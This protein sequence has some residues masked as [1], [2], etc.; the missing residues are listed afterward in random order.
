LKAILLDDALD[1][2][3]TD[4]EAGL[5]ELLGDDVGRGVEIEEA[6]TDDLSF[7]LL[8]AYVVALGPGLLAGEGLG[9]V[10]S[11]QFE[12]LI[13]PL[14]SQSQLLRGRSGPDAFAF[15]LDEHHEARCDEVVRR[16]DELTGGPDDEAS[17]EL[18]FH[19]GDL[20]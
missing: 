6:V 12:Q 5:A 16:D 20:S 13:I 3:G 8:G 7:E 2:P 4:G 10:L 15:A 18:Q 19:G 1:A 11:E 17:G 14:A 9:P